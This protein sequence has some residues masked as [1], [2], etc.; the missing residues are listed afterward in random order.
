LLLQKTKALFLLCCTE[1]TLMQAPHEAGEPPAGLQGPGSCH[2]K[3]RKLMREVGINFTFST[4]IV[5]KTKALFLLYAQNQQ[6]AECAHHVTPAWAKAVTR[7][8]KVK[9]EKR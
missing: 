8:A 3:F 6:I 9:L 2:G 5:P 4:H 7:P 1:H